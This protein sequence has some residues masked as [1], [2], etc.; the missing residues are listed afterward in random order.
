MCLYQKPT[1]TMSS[2]WFFPRAPME[3]LYTTVQLQVAFGQLE[4]GLHFWIW[5]ILFPPLMVR[6]ISKIN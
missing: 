1:V 5:F 3:A 6:F 4:P 2:C